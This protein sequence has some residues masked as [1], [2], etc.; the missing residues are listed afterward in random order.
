M[1]ATS[2]Y[3]ERR[4]RLAVKLIG[5]TLSR[6]HLFYDWFIVDFVTETLHEAG[7]KVIT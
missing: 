5:L 2:L 1:S 6:C 3:F 7:V 4:L